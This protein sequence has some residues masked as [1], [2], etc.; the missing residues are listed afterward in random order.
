[1][2]PLI[3][4]LALRRTI[5]N[6][7]TT[8]TS[9]EGLD[10]AAGRVLNRRYNADLRRSWLRRWAT[11]S[12]IPQSELIHAITYDFQA[13][14]LEGTGNPSDPAP[15]DTSSPASLDPR[16]HHRV[17]T[18]QALANAIYPFRSVGRS[19]RVLL[20]P[21]ALRHSSPPLDVPLRVR[22]QPLLIKTIHDAFAQE[23]SRH[24]L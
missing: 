18:L 10:L 16:S 13:R 24:F 22:P 4:E 11:V 7:L 19:A 6:P 12:N 8:S 9:T 3:R 20:L 23:F 17:P 2:A 15:S 1:M 21:M 14:S 5:R